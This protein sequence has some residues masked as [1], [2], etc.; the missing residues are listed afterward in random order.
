MMIDGLLSQMGQEFPARLG[1]KD[2]DWE[3]FKPAE[4][5]DLAGNH[6][7]R[8]GSFSGA[9]PGPVFPAM[10]AMNKPRFLLLD[11]HTQVP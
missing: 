7:S 3:R 2:S 9:A 6:T 8:V 4:G 10:V 5:T 1:P 11:E